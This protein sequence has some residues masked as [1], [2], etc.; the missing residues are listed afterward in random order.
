M[1]GGQQVYIEK[2]GAM[3][4]TPAHSSFDPNNGVA[5]KFQYAPGTP[6]GSLTTSALGADFLFSACPVAGQNNVWQV[7]AYARDGEKPGCV[8]FKG[9]TLPYDGPVDFQYD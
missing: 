2:F 7:Y 5:D 4:F 3:K 6:Y 8:F 9:L 1:P